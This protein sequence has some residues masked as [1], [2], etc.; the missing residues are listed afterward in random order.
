MEAGNKINRVEF[1]QRELI[2]NQYSDIDFSDAL[3][4][5][6]QIKNFQPNVYDI[7]RLGHDDM[8]PA[9]EDISVT[10]SRPRELSVDEDDDEAV[11]NVRGLILSRPEVVSQYESWS[12]V[13]LANLRARLIDDYGPEFDT[14]FVKHDIDAVY[15]PISGE[16]YARVATVADYENC[17]VD[18]DIIDIDPDEETLSL[19]PDISDEEALRKYLMIYGKSLDCFVEC[20]GDEEDIDRHPLIFGARPEVGTYHHAQSSI[21]SS[22]VQGEVKL[23]A[24]YE[25]QGS[26]QE[27]YDIQPE[28]PIQLDDIGGVFEVKQRLR[29]IADDL[30]DPE[31]A[32]MYDLEQTHFVLHGEPGTGKTSLIE[33]FANEAGAELKRVSTTDISDKYIGESAKNIDDIFDSAI[34]ESDDKPVVILMDEIDSI[35]GSQ[36]DGSNATEA[37]RQL[38]HRMNDLSRNH[39][40]I[41]VAAA[42][43]SGLERIDQAFLRSGRFEQIGITVPTELERKDIWTVLISRSD[44]RLR[45]LWRDQETK[46]YQTDI[47]IDEDDQLIGGYDVD[48]LARVT[49]GWTG[50]DINKA[51]EKGRRACRDH[52]KQTGQ[53]IQLT[54]ETLLAVIR[55]FNR[56]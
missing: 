21:G 13:Y 51:L 47:E 45:N 38:L 49:D 50:A 10:Y 43:N 5:F 4:Q 26:E 9:V 54:T 18:V 37:K 34:K 36:A 39:P 44:S 15:V 2:S 3:D 7:F 46:L 28:R 8:S 17:G 33:A 40:N 22:A 16:F 23:V 6:E 20:F 48:R 25:S 11:F 27:R 31:T 1:G 19:A 29:Q 12:S 35:I 55:D 42:T 56:Q 53:R 30:I 52:Y 24:S 32:A 41:I 14:R